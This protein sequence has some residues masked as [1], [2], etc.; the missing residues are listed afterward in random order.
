MIVMATEV[1]SGCLMM[2]FRGNTMINYLP[3]V[4]A[5]EH[6]AIFTGSVPSIDGIADNYWI[7][8]YS[9]KE[10]YVT[11]DSTVQSVG[12]N[13]NAGK[14][15]PRNLLVSTVTDELHIATNFQS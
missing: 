13:S 3:S 12:T 15:S 4:T 11:D 1:L 2:D 7:D 8:Q 5:V 10:T 6:T 14:M 9:G